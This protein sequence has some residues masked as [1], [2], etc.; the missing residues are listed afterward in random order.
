MPVRE[1]YSRVLHTYLQETEIY[2]DFLVIHSIS[3]LYALYYWDIHSS[4]SA[5]MGHKNYWIIML[6]LDGTVSEAKVLDFLDISYD[7]I[8]EML[9]SGNTEKRFT[10]R[11][12]D[13]DQFES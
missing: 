1:K 3:E 2:H 7:L 8:D 6:L 5:K 13:S 4:D 9:H 11:Y 10:Q 12:F